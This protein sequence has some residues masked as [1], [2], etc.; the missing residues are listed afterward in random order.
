MELLMSQYMAI[1]GLL[2]ERKVV[3]GYSN[4]TD[5]QFRCDIIILYLPWE[6]QVIGCTRLREKKR[7]SQLASQLIYMA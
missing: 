3:Q 7:S 4:E 1:Q 5:K 2:W 6:P